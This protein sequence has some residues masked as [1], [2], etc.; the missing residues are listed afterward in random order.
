MP[1]FVDQASITVI[2]GKGGN[3]AVAFHREKY[4]AAGGPDGGDGGRG[5]SV[6]LQA[7]DSMSTLMD[8]RYKRKYAAASGADGQGGLRSGKDGADLVIFPE[9]PTGFG[10]HDTEKINEG[11]LMMLS[12]YE[13]RAGKPLKIW[14]VRLD[15]D[16]KKMLIRA[17]FTMDP[18]VPL[19]D[20]TAERS[21]KVLHG[22]FDPAK[23][24]SD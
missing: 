19:R 7:D 13:K 10:E 1:M 12:M 15:L 18:A 24:E 17:P 9:I 6:I 11:W 5:G 23:T 22:I 14:P 2:A 20:Q 8:F 21:R 4:G 16:A 3:G